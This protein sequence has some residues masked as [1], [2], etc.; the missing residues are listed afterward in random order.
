MSKH[1]NMN[2]LLEKIRDFLDLI[3]GELDE[4]QFFVV[5]KGLEENNFIE[6]INQIKR[7]RNKIAHI[8]SSVNELEREIL[9]ASRPSDE[10]HVDLVAIRDVLISIK[11]QIN[12]FRKKIL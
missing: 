2:I 7:M 8:S 11:S 3:K 10:I 4:L 6:L 12:S 1:A 9:Y 5:S